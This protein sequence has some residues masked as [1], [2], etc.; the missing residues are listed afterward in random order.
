MNS[1]VSYIRLLL[2]TSVFLLV[3]A[4]GLLGQVE[5]N[6]FDKLQKEEGA[7][8]VKIYQSV[9]IASLVGQINPSSLK[10]V[11]GATY[12]S[13]K[14]YRV[15]L[16]AGNNQQVAKNEASSKANSF[17]EVFP[18]QKVYVTFAAPFWRVRVGNYLT[19]E[20]AQSALVQLKRMMPHQAKLMTIVKDEILLPY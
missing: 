10:S 13:S 1:T 17:R 15:Q 9:A 18:D 7:G 12:I 2:L 11:N 8:R 20:Q 5:S 19:Y 16:Y 6:I 14:G 4:V 3:G